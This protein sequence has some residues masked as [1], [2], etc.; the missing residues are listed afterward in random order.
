MATDFVK[1][2]QTPLFRPSGNS[3][4]EWDTSSANDASISCENVVKFGPVIPEFVTAKLCRFIFNS[5]LG[6]P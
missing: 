2:W 1:K 5:F 6:F 3:E 4:V